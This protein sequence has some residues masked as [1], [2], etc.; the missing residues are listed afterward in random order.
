M[1]E[2]LLITA[3]AAARM[4]SLSRTTFYGM[5]SSGHLGP[6]PIRF[7]R[8]VRWRADELRRWVEAGCP[9]RSQWTHTGRDV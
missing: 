8:S 2:R 5:H 4:L 1:N 3:D 9:P 7:G 6:L